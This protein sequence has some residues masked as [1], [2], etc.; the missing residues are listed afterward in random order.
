MTGQDVQLLKDRDQKLVRLRLRDGEVATVK[1]LF[2]SET[3]QDV[4]ADLVSS[5]HIARYPKDDVQ[6]TFQYLFSDI[7]SVEPIS[8]N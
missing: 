2:V 6:P 1:I 5:T 4:I 7:E 3:E 8:E